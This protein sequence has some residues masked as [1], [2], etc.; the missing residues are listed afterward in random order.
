MATN[1][2]SVSLTNL[3]TNTK[4][5][6]IITVVKQHKLLSPNMCNAV[7]PG[8]NP[9]GKGRISTKLTASLITIGIFHTLQA[10]T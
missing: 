9:S 3:D 10:I 2:Q 5:A 6:D 8:I 1:L 4:V 7:Q